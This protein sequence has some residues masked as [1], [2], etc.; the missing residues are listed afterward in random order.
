MNTILDTIKKWSIQTPNALCFD[1]VEDKLSYAELEKK[2]EILASYLQEHYPKREGIVVY[3]GHTSEVLISMIACTKSGHAYIPVDQHTPDDRLNLIVEESQAIAIISL[4]PWPLA[5]TV[6]DL[7]Q[8]TK[9]TTQAIEPVAL[10]P[11]VGDEIY[12]TI[13]TSGTTGKP[14]GVQI[15]FNNLKSY[16][17]W[18]VSDFN[19]K[20]GQRFLCQAPFSFDLSVMDLYPALLTGGAL[21][22]LHKPEVDHF[23]TLFKRLPELDLNVWVSTPSMVEI[24]LL[25]PD[26]SQEKLPNLIN[27]QFCGEELPRPVALKLMERFPDADIFNTYGPT[28]A[29]VAVTSV[30]LTEKLLEE[31]DR[32]PLGK[33][34]SDTRLLIMSEE[35]KVLPD[36]EIG[37]II[38]I[39]PPV[40][41]GYFNNEEKTKEA[42]FTYEGE[43]AYRTGDAGLL[44]NGL[45]FY[46]GRL[47]FQVKW[48]GFRIEL[49]DIDHHLLALEAVRSACVV[50]KYNKLHKV[51]QL[52]AFVVVNDQFKDTDEKELAKELKQQLAQKVME[53]MVPQKI[54]I[55]ESLP[56]SVNGKV[57]RKALIGQVNNT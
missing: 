10:S 3:G 57:D 18:M 54:D 43:Q 48:H 2:S 45:L 27:F 53:Y 1:D 15:S 22:P 11:V 38:I 37:E 34:K 55:V 17:D 6:I 30:K 28:E 56:L 42:F 20:T 26:F 33:V 25:S 9:I 19:L 49:G 29:T 40:S 21:I 41:Q 35:G 31:V 52:I 50:P 24:C 12:Y 5:S 36:G 39:G 8:F 32:L 46:K 14:K 47:D 4:S 51:Q 44:K 7:E 23:P 16:T 13:F